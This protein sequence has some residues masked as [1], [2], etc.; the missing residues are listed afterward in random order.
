[1]TLDAETLEAAA[2]KLEE[3]AGNPIYQ[4]AWKAAAKFLRQLKTEE[5]KPVN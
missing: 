4:K 1:M 2:R 3:R 5:S